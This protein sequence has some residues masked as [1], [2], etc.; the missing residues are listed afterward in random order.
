MTDLK[1]YAILKRLLKVIKESVKIIKN[2]ISQKF[3][4]VEEEEVL[5][6]AEHILKY[7]KNSS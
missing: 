3:G 6:L 2:K 1:R 7:T 4:I 5:R